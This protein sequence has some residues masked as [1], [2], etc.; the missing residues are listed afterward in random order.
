MLSLLADTLTIVVIESDL[1]Y[2]QV[3]SYAYGLYFLF[4]LIFLIV[5]VISLLSDDLCWLLIGYS[6]LDCFVPNLAVSLL[7]CFKSVSTLHC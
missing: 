2:C 7:G 4:L 3:F 5:S 6:L 1:S